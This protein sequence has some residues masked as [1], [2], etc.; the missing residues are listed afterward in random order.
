MTDWP[1]PMNDLFTAE[2]T[3][4]M[5]A[6]P[7]HNGAV[8]D[9]TAIDAADLAVMEIPPGVGDSNPDDGMQVDAD[10]YLIDDGPDLLDSLAQQAK[11][12]ESIVVQVA[13]EVV[14]AHPRI[15]IDESAILIGDI[16]EKRHR[17]TVK[18]STLRAVVADCQSGRG[19]F[20]PEYVVQ[21]APAD[22]WPAPPEPAAFHGL[23]GDLVRA[24]EDVTEAD[25]VALLGTTLALFGTLAGPGCA[26]YQGSAQ[27]P[28]LYVVLVGDTGSGRKGTALAVAREAFAQAYPAYNELLV[29]GLGSGEGLISRLRP[30]ADGACE[31]RALVL[32]SEYSR[33][34]TVMGREGSTLSPVLRDGW[35]G[36]PM[37][38]FLARESSLVLN[39]HVGLLGHVTP[40]ELRDKLRD[41]DAASGYGN[42]HLWLAVR[43]TRL[44]PFPSNPAPLITPYVEALHRAI[45]EA[46]PPRELALTDD[47]RDR[48]EVLYSE[49]ALRKRWGLAGA[50]TARA[51]A[52]IVRLALVYALMDRSSNIE[53]CH[54]EAGIALEAY[55]DR[56]VRYIFGDSTGDPHADEIRRI[57]RGCDGMTRSE[58]RFETG[59]HD[60]PK[61]ARAIDKLVSLQLVTVARLA[62]SVKGGPKA[63][64]IRSTEGPDDAS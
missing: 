59:I 39:H 13:R 8:N 2:Q 31:P 49:L 56:S 29:P 15:R 18:Q 12:R 60:G 19:L 28:N 20:A 25:P 40:V 6:H 38:R 36:S 43:R 58:L 23:A 16:L 50:L 62:G 33:L 26:V 35:D 54:L 22:P 46:Q 1:G 24:V 17:F 11:E 47:A 42:R 44:L 61:L 3:R 10:G 37:G 48:W 14:E 64:L 27:R 52:Q 53:T 4:R 7:H 41:T 51:E 34:L 9:I 55:A 21:N 63:E 5:A 30:A 45:A 32:E 57:L